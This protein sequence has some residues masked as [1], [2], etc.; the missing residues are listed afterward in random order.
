MSI[1]TIKIYHSDNTTLKGQ[2]DYDSS[3]GVKIGSGQLWYPN[4]QLKLKRSYG[5][6]NHQSFYENG[7]PKSEYTVKDGKKDGLVKEWYSNGKPKSEYTIKDGKKD[8]SS[9]FWFKSGR[10]S[11]SNYVNGIKY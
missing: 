1:Q 5:N 4:G 3:K 7:E 10:L 11:T 2:Y 9:H 6:G 8:G